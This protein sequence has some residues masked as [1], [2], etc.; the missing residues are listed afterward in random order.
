MSKIICDICGT[1]YADTAS[2]CPICGTAKS[3][4][5]KAVSADPAGE[6]G[7]D[8]A[9]VKGGRFSPNNVKKRN[10]NQELP[11][12]NAPVKS[13]KQEKAPAQS[14]APKS[15]PRQKEKEESSSNVGLIIIVVILVLA[16]IAVCAYIAIRF[17]DQG[18]PDAGRPSVPGTSATQTTGQATPPRNVPCTGLTLYIKELTFSQVGD[19]MLLNVKADPIDT[20]DKLTYSSSDPYVAIVDANGKVTAVAN[21]T[22]VI[23]IR[24]GSFEEQCQ[25]T[26]AV[27]V[28][29]SY[30]TE[31]T[32]PPT[33]P[34]EP[35]PDYVLQIYDPYGKRDIS[36][37]GYGSTHDF[38][39]RVDNGPSRE[40]ITWI[41]DNEN[42]VTVVNGVVTAVGNGTTNVHIIY[43]SQ[44]IVV[45]VRC[46]NVEGPKEYEV[47]T[48]YGL[49]NDI[50]IKVGESLTLQLVHKETGMRVA[51]ENLTFTVSKEGYVSVDEKGRVTGVDVNYAGVWVYI[52]YEGVTYKCLVRV[53]PKPEE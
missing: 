36:L 42:V 13:A 44:E 22:A 8:Y 53:Q 46:N 9:Y 35:Y 43:G 47:R 24:C 27:G 6:Q 34:V 29:P 50:S 52:E 11:R 12:E 18:D 19:S 14:K 3:D 25:I 28:D 2:Q 23:T 41:S 15:Q 51:A 26:C 39:K 45:I 37:S 16:I 4:A 17:I 48:I 21:G 40:E 30:P 49:A 10:A 5:A 7:G 33:V 20:T 1:A 31:P 38:Y 32:Q